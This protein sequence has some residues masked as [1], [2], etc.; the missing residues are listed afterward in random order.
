[1]TVNGADNET[2]TLSQKKEFVPFGRPYPTVAYRV[3]DKQWEA[4]GRMSN[5]QMTAMATRQ[6]RIRIEYESTLTSKFGR[7]VLKVSRENAKR[8]MIR[9]SFRHRRESTLFDNINGFVNMANIRIMPRPQL[10]SSVKHVRMM[11]C[12]KEMKPIV[13]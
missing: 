7:C 11:E 4:N 9:Y 3:L 5:N 13:F 2:G 8:A 1:L 12:K 10:P 6:F